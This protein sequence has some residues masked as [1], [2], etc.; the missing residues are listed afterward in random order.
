MQPA[1]SKPDDDTSAGCRDETSCRMA[2]NLDGDLCRQTRRRWSGVFELDSLQGDPELTEL[3]FKHVTVE[4]LVRPCVVV[5]RG[6][7]PSQYIKTAC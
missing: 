3:R 7:G 5:W 1:Q 4:S 2:A 6:P